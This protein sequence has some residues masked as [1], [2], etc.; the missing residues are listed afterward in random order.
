ME[1]NQVA[2]GVLGLGYVG[3]PLALAFSRYFRVVGYDPNEVRVGQLVQG[4]DQT[5]EVSGEE[6]AARSNIRF[7]ADA[8]ELAGCNVY[9]VAVP[10]PV[11]QAM[12][13]DLRPLVDA[14]RVVG[15]QL[16]PGDT[17]IFESTVYPGTTEEVCVPELERVSG[18]VFNKDF[19]CGYSPERINPGDRNRRL[20]S[21]CKVTSGSTEAAAEFV[22]ALYR[23]VIV[24]GT[25][26]AASI[27]VAEAAKVV[28][29]TQRDV[30]IALMNEL[31]MIF[32][33]IG[34][35][36]AQVLSAA[37]TKW[38][39]LP[40]SPG[41]VGGHCIG[42]D[43]YYLTHKASVMGYHPELL[44]TSRRINNRMGLYVANRLMRLMAEKG[45][46][47]VGARILVLGLA[48]KENCPDLRN[49][50]VVEI[51]EELRK[52]NA[53][54]DVWDPL[55]DQQ[56]AAQALGSPLVEPVPGGR[57]YDAILL[58]VPHAPFLE[59]P[60]GWLDSLR[61]E[62]SVVFDVKSVLPGESVDG[63]L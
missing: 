12:T 5:G 26:K 59:G 19:S 10:T 51:T 8:S 44:L 21:I 25:Y 55:V 18:L 41:L 61:K 45:I 9:I 56:E 32:H 54:V 40:F 13:P 30:N 48:F 37:A 24:A 49:T 42:V 1:N 47:V 35:D 60:E 31:A 7:T 28:E 16:K 14:C 23:K 3:L 15:G 62:H 53:R 58:A 57:A 46:S 43:P 6:L 52:L 34:V 33:V 27:R 11:D 20:E 2:I 22:D 50:R 29:N 36:T 17:V 38:N 39:F 4:R 63:R